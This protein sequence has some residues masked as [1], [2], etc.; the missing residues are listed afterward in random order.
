MSSRG[1]RPLN[2]SISSQVSPHPQA[3]EVACVLNT[4][5]KIL[6]ASAEIIQR[7]EVYYSHLPKAI[8]LVS[9]CLTVVPTLERKLMFTYRHVGQSICSLGI[10]MGRG[11]VAPSIQRPATS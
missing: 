8:E 9:V 6:A 1:P 2:N 11:Y 5:A 4:I 3:H 7:D 10:S